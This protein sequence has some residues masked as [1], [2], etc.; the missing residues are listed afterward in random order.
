MDSLTKDLES[1]FEKLLFRT[2]PNQYE[3]LEMIIL[4]LLNQELSVNMFL[5]EI[6]IRFKYGKMPY[7]QYWIIKELMKSKDNLEK[8]LKINKKL[9]N[10]GWFEN[11]DNEQFQVVPILDY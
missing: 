10:R 8:N 2:C 1:E 4:K 6:C 7:N 3:E 9:S 11:D 5:T